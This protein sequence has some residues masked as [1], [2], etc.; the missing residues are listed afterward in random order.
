MDA[1]NPVVAAKRA[2]FAIAEI[3]VVVDSFDR[4]GT[5]VFDALDAIHV[6]VEGYRAVPEARRD[7]A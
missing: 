6:A 1:Q 4:G 5:N 3:K 7:A 2:I